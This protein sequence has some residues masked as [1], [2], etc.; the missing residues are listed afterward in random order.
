VHR[1]RVGVILIDHSEGYDEA[2]TLWA[3]ATGGTPQVQDPPEY[4]R[5]RG[6]GT[7]DLV[8]S[9]GSRRH[10]GGPAQAGVPGVR[11]GVRQ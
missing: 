4:T 11:G 8:P 1:S 5:L 2:E 9:P 7:L 3:R 10:P 6:V